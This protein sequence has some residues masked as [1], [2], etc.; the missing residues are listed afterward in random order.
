MPFV[1]TDRNRNTT[2]IRFTQVMKMH[3]FI[4]ALTS[5]CQQLS[6]SCVC[7]YRVTTVKYVEVIISGGK[8]D[9]LRD[10]SVA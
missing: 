8:G 3:L 7:L 5:K 10:I 1:R 4:S 9:K 6:G 2:S